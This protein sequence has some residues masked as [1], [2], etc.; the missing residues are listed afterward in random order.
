MS[1]KYNT[2]FFVKFRS[3]IRKYLYGLTD[4]Y[5]LH[6]KSEKPADYSLHV[7]FKI[8][9]D[10]A[11]AHETHITTRYEPGFEKN[12]DVCGSEIYP[13]QDWVIEYKVNKV[14]DAIKKYYLNN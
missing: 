6:K 10:A 1:R 4:N 3:E 12:Q 7:I 5:F 13:Q 14:Q 11:K 8:A 9:K 2:K